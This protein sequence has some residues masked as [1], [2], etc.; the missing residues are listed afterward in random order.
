M[1][2]AR[3]GPGQPG[4]ARHAYRRRIYRGCRQVIRTVS[5]AR[6]QQLRQAELAH[7]PIPASE[8]DG[9]R[10]ASWRGGL[11]MPAGIGP[12][13]G[14]RPDAVA[15]DGYLVAPAVKGDVIRPLADSTIVPG[16][17]FRPTSSPGRRPCPARCVT[18][19]P[20]GPSTPASRYARRSRSA[21]TLPASRRM[22][23]S[24]RRVLEGAPPSGSTITRRRSG[25]G[26][27]CTS[28]RPRPTNCATT[29]LRRWRAGSNVQHA[30]GT[31]ARE[32]SR[33]AGSIRSHSSE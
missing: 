11:V 24:A 28:L 33:L 26:M 32:G 15:A 1:R 13:T 19:A 4:P 8:A 20:T 27:P 7:R 22:A 17:W 12:D 3:A 29:R 6:R 25:P 5:S 9:G 18:A 21:S 30:S 16:P 10:R 31:Y 2:S 23:R 14:G